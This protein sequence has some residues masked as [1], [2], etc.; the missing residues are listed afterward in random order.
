MS[1]GGEARRNERE[2]A[3]DEREPTRD[4]LDAMAYVDGELAPDARR[5][6]EARLALEPALA[7]EVAELRELELVARQV[8]PPE[9]ADH[10][11]ARIERS[12]LTRTL[13]P[14]AWILIGCAAL[15]LVAWT[16][17]I[18][19]TCELDLVPKLCVLALTLGLLLLGGLSVRNRLRTLPYD[20]Y[21]KLK[22]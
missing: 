6:F 8:A 17:W 18:E 9:P 11:W 12:A 22:R 2:P 4:E 5:V 20:P 15:G 1:G 19:C 7:R 10:E 3:R 21:T 13:H 16:L 14:F